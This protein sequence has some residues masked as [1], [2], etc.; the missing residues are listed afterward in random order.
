MFY[1]GGAVSK[2]PI[3]VPDSNESNHTRELVFMLAK[4]SAAEG[5]PG[6]IEMLEQLQDTCLCEAK[7]DE[8]GKNLHTHNNT[9]FTS[10]K[11]YTSCALEG[12]LTFNRFQK[13]PLKQKM[14]FEILS[15]AS[16]YS[17]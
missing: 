11:S 12:V 6:Q 3:V 10:Y 4:S 1:M 8:G 15:T 7:K 14:V 2:G 17:L 9:H 13:R 16:F 5:K